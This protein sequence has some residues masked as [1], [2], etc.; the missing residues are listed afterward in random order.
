MPRLSAVT[1]IDRDPRGREALGYGLEADGCRV[2]TSAEYVPPAGG[3]PPEVAVVVARDPAEP[4]LALARSLRSAGD[5]RGL[6]VVVLGPPALRGEARAIPG[7]DFLPLPAYVRDVATACK[8]LA[9]AEPAGDEPAVSGAL[10]DFGLYFLLRTLLGLGRSAVLQVERGNRRGELRFLEGQVTAAQVGPLQGSAAVHQLLLW[11]EAALDLKLRSV[12]HRGPMQQRAEELLEEAERF[13]RDFAHA[14]KDLGPLGTALHPDQQKAAA[15]GEPVLTEVTPVLRLFDGQ[16]TVGDVLEDSPFRVFE[17]LRV[18]N[19]LVELGILTPSVP[20][21][22]TG[23]SPANRLDPWVDGTPAPVVTSTEGSTSKTTRPIGLPAD[24]RVGPASR[25][26]PGQRREPAAGEAA[27]PAASGPAPGRDP[28][29]ASAAATTAATTPA[30]A[31]AATS[32]AAGVLSARG[33]LRSSGTIEIRRVEP[34]PAADGAPSVVVDP[35]AFDPS[36][37]ARAVGVV[38]GR[39]RESQSGSQTPGSSIQ[40]DPGLMAELLAI[41]M[42][43]TPATPR[44]EVIQP[45]AAAEAATPSPAREGNGRAAAA[46]TIVGLP[47]APD[48]VAPAAQAGPA[49]M[50]P[51]PAEPAPAITAPVPTAA[52]AVAT[53]PSPASTPVPTTADPAAAVP[54]P[55]PAVSRGGLRRPSSEFNAVERDFFDREADLYKE[56]PTESFEDIGRKTPS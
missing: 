54:T 48:P 55:P 39:T 7:V 44:P 43:N 31:V 41:E 30:P 47:T 5:G 42:A 24:Q 21:A 13:L 51:A 45:A 8:L 33:E 23:T 26:R 32:P 19:R 2:T 49:E 12:V 36:Q 46:A 6:P 53:A 27:A 28:A 17:T 56:E 38:E 14:T 3:E 35:G 4:A 25:R 50:A 40:L 11:E 18:V 15:V 29:P 37:S 22:P 10:S 16:R 1:V 20:A 9:A 52:P 34:R